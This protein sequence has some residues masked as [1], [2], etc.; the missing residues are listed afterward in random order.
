MFAAM[1]L[2]LALV[3]APPLVRAWT[4]PTGYRTTI[5]GSRDGVCFYATTRIVGAV[6][7]S[8]GRQLWEKS[9]R[10]VSASDLGPT[11]IALSQGDDET[12]SLVVL[13]LESG[14]ELASRP[15]PQAQ[16]LKVDGATIYAVS[17]A[18]LQLYSDKLA[19]VTTIKLA[20]KAPKFPGQLAISG[21]FLAVALHDHK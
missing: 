18:T 15:A 21:D 11:F 6:R 12:D 4:L 3:Q 20:D 13:D 5:L 1:T 7:E 16:A 17:G 14:T 19:P 8:D 2:C 9:F 10:S